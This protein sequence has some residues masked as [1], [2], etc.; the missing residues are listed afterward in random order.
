MSS[1]ETIARYDLGSPGNLNTIRKAL[2]S[3]EILDFYEK[4]PGFVN[5][6]FEFWLRERFFK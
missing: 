4:E 2:E 5:P 1:S 3:K 6:L